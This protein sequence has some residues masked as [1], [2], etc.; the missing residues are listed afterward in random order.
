MVKFVV[1]KVKGGC[2]LAQLVVSD[3]DVLGSVQTPM[4]MLYTRGG[5]LTFST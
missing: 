1:K 2:R 5:E 4:C 3:K